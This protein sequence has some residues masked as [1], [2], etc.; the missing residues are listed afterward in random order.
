MAKLFTPEELEE[1]RR[2]D[3][4]IEE[5]FSLS[6]EDWK[7]SKRLDRDA[8][9]DGLDNRGRKI[10]AQ[11]AAYR[12]ANKEKI[13]DYQAAYY[14][15]NKEKIADYQAAYREANRGKYNAYMR[16][17]LR[18]RREAKKLSRQGDPGTAGGGII[19]DG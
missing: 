19:S 8:K 7:R 3:E 13:A 15:A 12:E 10:A 17:Y 5:S 1:I 16:D 6:Q 14:E 2:A 4:E 11:Q 9:L 18:K